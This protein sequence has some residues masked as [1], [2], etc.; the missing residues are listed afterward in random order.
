MKKG[1]NIISAVWED[2]GYRDSE[3]DVQSSVS[4]S[5]SGHDGGT[6]DS[7]SGGDETEKNLVP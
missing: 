7:Q 3:E 4:H 2:L 1:F 6:G 5:P